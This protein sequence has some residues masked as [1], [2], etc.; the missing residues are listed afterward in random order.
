MDFQDFQENVVVTDGKTVHLVVGPRVKSIILVQRTSVSNFILLILFSPHTLHYRYN[1]EHFPSS[2]CVGVFEGFWWSFI[3][4]TT[5]GYG[6]TLV[7]SVPAKIYSVLW[8]L[9]GII[10]FTFLTSLFTA[11]LM[12]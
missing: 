5:V 1:K 11:E 9:I 4:M 2:F 7:R 3:S 6:D 12:M 8:I 10:M